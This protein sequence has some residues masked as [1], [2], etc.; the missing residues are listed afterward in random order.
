[1]NALILPRFVKSRG[2]PLHCLYHWRTMTKDVDDIEF[3]HEYGTEI[4]EYSPGRR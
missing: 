1:M 4:S 3:R 2:E